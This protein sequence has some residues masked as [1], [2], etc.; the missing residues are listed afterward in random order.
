[1]DIRVTDA[2]G[3]DAHEHILITGGRDGDPLQ[4]QWLSRLNHTNGFHADS[5]P[6]IPVTPTHPWPSR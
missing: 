6:G 3:A 4:F 5:P 1:M 2:G